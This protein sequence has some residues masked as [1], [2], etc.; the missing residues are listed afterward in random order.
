MAP[1]EAPSEGQEQALR[2]IRA[3]AKA[4]GGRLTVELSHYLDEHRSL[5]IRIWLAS[6]SFP[7]SDQGID[8]EEWEPVRPGHSVGLPL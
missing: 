2:S 3:L 6:A 7:A 8:F 1:L 5:S 4:S